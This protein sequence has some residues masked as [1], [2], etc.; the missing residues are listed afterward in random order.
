V[1]LSILPAAA[2]V[3]SHSCTNFEE[4][5]NFEER[6]WAQECGRA[7][8]A[9]WGSGECAAIMG[10]ELL[11]SAEAGPAEGTFSVSVSY[12]HCWWMVFRTCSKPASCWGH[13][14]DEYVY[15]IITN[16]TRKFSSFWCHEI[17]GRQEELQSTSEQCLPTKQINL[18]SSL[19]RSV[20]DQ[21]LARRMVEW[22][23]R[24]T[25]LGNTV[26]LFVGSPESPSAAATH[27]DH[28]V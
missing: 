19:P 26:T 3:A 21:Q 15:Y 25:V 10:A 18:R 12:L 20:A 6:L 11:H 22:A 2:A 8:R 1:V 13:G 14:C 24:R 9:L 17:S 27:D 5:T 28:G 7:D 16:N 4:S 23:W